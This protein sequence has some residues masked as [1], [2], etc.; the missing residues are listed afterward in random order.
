MTDAPP[1][2][3]DAVA[4]FIHDDECV[5]GTTKTCGR[6]KSSAHAR[7]IEFYQQ[8]A[9]DILDTA[10]PHIAAAIWRDVNQLADDYRVPDRDLI[11]AMPFGASLD[12]VM[13]ERYGATEPA[14]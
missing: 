12:Q 7:H 13:T 1:A 4:E 5:G 2:A 9:R 8:K 10:L 6:W 3:V 14:P 11:A